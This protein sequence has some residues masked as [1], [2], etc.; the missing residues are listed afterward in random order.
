MKKLIFLSLA[1]SV[2][3]IPS[4]AQSVD[5]S[6]GYS[7][8]RLGGSGGIRRRRRFRRVP[9]LPRRRFPEH[10][11]LSLRSSPDSAEPLEN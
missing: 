3:A 10:L 1:L 11:H 9:C 7:Y 4:C 8:F 5:V 6:V 2:F